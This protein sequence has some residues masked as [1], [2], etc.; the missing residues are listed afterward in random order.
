M[1]WSSLFKFSTPN[2][3][4]LVGDNIWISLTL[5]HFELNMGNLLFTKSSIVLKILS[6]SSLLSKK[7]SPPFLFKYGNSPLF[8]LWAFKI[9][10]LSFP[11]LKISFNLTTL[12]KSLFIKSLNTFPGPT[13]GNWSTSPTI[14]TLVPNL[15]AFNKLFISIISIIDA[16]SIIITS[17]SNGSPSPFPKNEFSS[18][19]TPISNNLCIVFA[20]RPVDSVILL[21]ALPVGA[22]KRTFIPLFS[23]I[24]IIH[25][26]IVVFPVPGPPVIISIPFSKAPIIAS[27]WESANL[28]LFL[29]SKLD[30]SKAI[31]EFIV[32][33][34]SILK[35]IILFVTPNSQK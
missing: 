21:A 35:V 23:Y 15:I 34:F 3:P 31:S 28:I 20:S 8:I 19:L 18:S 32:W 16:S 5:F 10:M 17:P 4:F 2:T 13:D 22:A 7:K 14:I 29:L 24:S 25:L 11:C 33:K 9:I 12:I 27:F 26:I 30:I 1:A 6:L